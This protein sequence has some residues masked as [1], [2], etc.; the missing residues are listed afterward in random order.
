M[1]SLA[2]FSGGFYL[3]GESG[4]TRP[5]GWMMTSSPTVRSAFRTL[6]ISAVSL[7]P[8]ELR[9]KARAQVTEPGDRL[10]RQAPLFVMGSRL[11]A[12]FLGGLFRSVGDVIL[13]RGSALNKI[14]YG[15]N[16]Q[17]DRRMARKIYRT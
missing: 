1:G 7:P 3:G 11:A 10:Q 14:P 5:R 12:E 8:L 2:W 17:P 15:K 9:Q 16:K 13:R 6:P 4:T